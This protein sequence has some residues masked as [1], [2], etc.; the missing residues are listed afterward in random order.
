MTNT[1]S[2]HTLA[3]EALQ[4][5]GHDAYFPGLDTDTF[6]PALI[7]SNYL[8]NNPTTWASTVDGGWSFD[9]DLNTLAATIPSRV[10][11]A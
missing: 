8:D 6:D 10:A 4:V 1:Q 2:T 9:G 5:E 7:L 3:T 11:S